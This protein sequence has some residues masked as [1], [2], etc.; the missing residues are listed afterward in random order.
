M[1][2]PP[3]AHA[4]T[5]GGNPVSCAAAMATLRL[6]ENGMMDNATRM[7]N[8]VLN[9][10]QKTMKT[11]YSIGDIRGRGL[12][13][14]IEIVKDRREDKARATALR[15]RIIQ[16]A[17]TK[18]LLLLGAGNNAIRIIPPLNIT[19]DIIDEG[20]DIFEKVLVEENA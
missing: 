8:H 16:N 11:H 3:G 15:N 12:M 6:L 5:F 2:W 19:Q 18:G 13:I 7:G 1:T 4:S 10:L 20:L 14:G 9:R 17:F